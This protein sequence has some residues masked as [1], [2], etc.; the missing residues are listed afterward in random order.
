MAGI[1][2]IINIMQGVNK[3][4]YISPVHRKRYSIKCDFYYHYHY[5]SYFIYFIGCFCLFA[6]LLWTDALGDLFCS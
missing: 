5:Y 6:C 1:V 2:M 3:I 4:I